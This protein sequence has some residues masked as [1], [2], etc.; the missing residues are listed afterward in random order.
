[1]RHLRGV[2]FCK[3]TSKSIREGKYVRDVP[4]VVQKIE[5]KGP[6]LVKD[7]EFIRTRA[8]SEGTIKMTLPGP[9]TVADTV[10]DEVYD[11]SM[12]AL[13]SDYADVIRKEIGNLIDAGCRAIQIDDP[14][15]L[16]YPEQAREWGIEV[17]QRCFSGYEEKATWFVHICR[18]YPD[19]TSEQKGI[20]YKANQDNYSEILEWLSTSHVD[21]ISIEGAQGNLDLSVLQAA[22]EKTVMLG[23]LDVGSDEVEGVSDLVQRGTKAL[24]YVPKERLILAP[25]CGMFQLSRRSARRKLANMA[26]AASILNQS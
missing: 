12:Q 21:V 5:H 23:V 13:A 22:G 26:K 16:R 6:F 7:F 24:R 19:K 15:L 8:G 20:K 2:D 1:M 3:L 18:G 17:L 25:D 11:G 9:I 14:V 4:T 10:A